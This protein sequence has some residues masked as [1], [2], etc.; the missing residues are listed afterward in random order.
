M[1]TGNTLVT[2]FPTF[3]FILKKIFALARIWA[4]HRWNTFVL[5]FRISFVANFSSI[6]NFLFFFVGFVSFHSFLI[7]DKWQNQQGVINYYISAAHLFWFVFLSYYIG[8]VWCVLKFI[9]L[10]LHILIINLNAYTYSFRFI[11]IVI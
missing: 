6:H 4:I 11:L 2:S 8:L 1:C 10:F 3:F 5:L 9:N 7:W